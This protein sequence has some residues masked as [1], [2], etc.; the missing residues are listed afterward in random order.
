MALK[1][2]ELDKPAVEAAAQA[3][4]NKS[5]DNMMKVIER[6]EKKVDLQSKK[7]RDRLLTLM[8]TCAGQLSL[9]LLLLENLIVDLVAAGREEVEG[10]EEEEG[11]ERCYGS[12]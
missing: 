6:L 8:H 5:Y 10:A 12:G 9:T 4:D 11:E 7:V 1:K 3:P 2:M